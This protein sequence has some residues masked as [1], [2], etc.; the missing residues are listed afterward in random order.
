MTTHPLAPAGQPFPCDRPIRPRPT[1]PCPARLPTPARSDY[2]SLV[3]PST[4]RPRLPAQD[5]V[6]PIPTAHPGPTR[7]RSAPTRP[8]S[9]RLPTPSVPSPPRRPRPVRFGPAHPLP[10]RLPVPCQHTSTRPI[11][12]MPTPPMATQ[13]SADCPCLPRTAT[14]LPIPTT[15]P[16]PSTPSRPPS[17][18]PAPRQSFATPHRPDGPALLDPTTPVHPPRTTPSRLDDPAPDW[19]PRP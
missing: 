10:F 6:C 19:T 16:S 13:L 11:S 15:Q 9:T 17:D 14:R 2:P 7:A 12:D 8:R 5:V 3:L 18:Y 4:T 1:R